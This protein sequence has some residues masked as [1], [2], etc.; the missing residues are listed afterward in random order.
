MAF[1]NLFEPYALTVKIEYVSS[2]IEVIVFG[3]TFA[4]LPNT[5][6]QGN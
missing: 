6:V 4:K 2:K 1:D 5:A 3:C